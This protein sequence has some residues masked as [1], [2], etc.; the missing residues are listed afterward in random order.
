MES[1]VQDPLTWRRTLTFAEGGSYCFQA[2]LLL[3]LLALAGCGSPERFREPI[4]KFTQAATVT[5][6]VTRPY[7][8]DLNRTERRY[9]LDQISMDP[10]LTL[11]N[12]ALQPFFSPEGV[13][14]RLEMFAAIDRYVT[15]LGQVMDTDAGERLGANIDALGGNLTSLNDR[16]N[17]GDD[18]SLKPYIGPLGALVK[19]VGQ[20]WVDAERERILQTAVQDA[21]PQVDR[22]LSL[23]EKDVQQAYEDRLLNSGIRID[24]LRQDYN[25]RRL[26]VAGQA[27]LNEQQRRQRLDEI[28]RLVTERELLGANPPSDLIADMRLTHGKLVAAAESGGELGSYADFVA[29][30]DLFSQRAQTVSTALYDLSRAGR[31]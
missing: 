12:Q 20:M 16:L 2:V 9:Q 15:R 6:E 14:I 10:K 31:I 27:A 21:A 25:N 17:R 30:V 13:R 26:P 24:D 8:A 7:I 22:I 19:A 4:A 29:A 3:V 28:E 5:A 11:D 23:L 1:R 18:P